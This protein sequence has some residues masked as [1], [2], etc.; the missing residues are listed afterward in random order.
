MSRWLQ[1]F[2]Y[3]SC[4]PLGPFA[5]LAS[6]PM[7]RGHHVGGAPRCVKPTLV[8]SHDARTPRCGTATLHEDHDAWV[9]RCVSATQREHPSA[10][11]PPSGGAL[12]SRQGGSTDQER[13]AAARYPRETRAPPEHPRVSP[14]RSTQRGESEQGSTRLRPFRPVFSTW[15]RG[16]GARASQARLL[17]PPHL[18]GC[19]PV[20]LARP[21][22][23]KA[24]A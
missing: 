16:A 24:R 23:R 21:V 15:V 22:L 20:R 3:S 1:N 12:I 11:P 13:D 7:L 6:R 14:V 4:P 10:P 9:P 2:L 8:T 18:G 5:A 19:F 17:P